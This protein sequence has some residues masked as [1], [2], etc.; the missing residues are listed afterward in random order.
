MEQDGRKSGKSIGVGKGFERPYTAE[1]VLRLR[2]SVM[3]EHTL[4]RMG[5]ERLW[6]LMHE[7][8]YVNALGAM[9]GN[10]AVQMVQ[11]GLKAIYLS[12]WQ[13]AADANSAGQTYP[14]Q[15]LYPAD[16][17]PKLVKR[18]NNALRRADQIYHVNDNNDIYWF[19]PIVADAESGFGGILNAFRTDEGDD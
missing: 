6:Q 11:A 15:S 19:A 2:G 5:A 16:S 3:I 14:D 10:Q 8:D 13:V 17:A 9:T 7:E 12:G 4:A 18:I 1:D